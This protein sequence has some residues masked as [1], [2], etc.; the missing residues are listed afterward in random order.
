MRQIYITFRSLFMIPS[1]NSRQ[2]VSD[3]N[4]LPAMVVGDVK[5]VVYYLSLAW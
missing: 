3:Y 2:I 5:T 1:M 4:I